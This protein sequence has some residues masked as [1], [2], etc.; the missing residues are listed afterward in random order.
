VGAAVVSARGPKPDQYV[1]IAKDLAKVRRSLNVALR[2]C[3]EN[4]VEDD[5]YVELLVYRVD[6]LRVEVAA[7]RAELDS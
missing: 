6:E 4:P 1:K 2:T 7:L 3:H 5:E